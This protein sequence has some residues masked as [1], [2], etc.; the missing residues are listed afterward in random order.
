[1]KY[2][3]FVQ[4]TTVKRFAVNAETEA[5]AIKQVEQDIYM[6][7]WGLV[8]THSTIVCARAKAEK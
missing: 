7:S 8:D 2:E 3:V 1:M 6:L 5:E 4:Q